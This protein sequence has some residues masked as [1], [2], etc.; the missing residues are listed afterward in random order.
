MDGCVG[1][2]VAGASVFFVPDWEHELCGVEP[3]IEARAE[4]SSLRL[5]IARRRKTEGQLLLLS[6][7]LW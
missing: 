1:R 6:Q 7:L 2:G 3:T 4:L 5:W